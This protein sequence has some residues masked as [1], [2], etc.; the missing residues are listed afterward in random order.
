MFDGEGTVPPQAQDVRVINLSIGDP[1]RPFV[2]TPSPWARLLDWLAWKYRVLFCV[3]AGNYTDS[4][5]IGLPVPQ[6][7]ALPDEEKSKHMLKCIEMQ[8][9]GRRVLSPAESINA[10]TVGALHSDSSGNTYYQG[11]VLIYCHMRRYS[12]LSHG[13]GTV[14]AGLSSRKSSSQVAGS[15]IKPRHWIAIQCT[16]PLAGW[17]P[18]GRRL[19][20]TAT[21]LVP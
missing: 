16:N 3:S 7:A 1:T 15:C 21:G 2:R 20:G 4:I 9:S 11:G 18:R 19:L 12:V 8:L 14:S 10:I 6:H 5:D 17:L 13:W